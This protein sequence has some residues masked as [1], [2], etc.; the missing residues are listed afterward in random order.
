M[1]RSR[2]KTS[3]GKA[4]R[5]PSKRGMGQAFTRTP[6]GNSPLARYIEENRETGIPVPELIQ[7]FQEYDCDHPE[8]LQQIVAQGSGYR[9]I[10]C[11]RCH[12]VEKKSRPGGRDD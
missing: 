9:F 3:Y 11:E 4:R 2:V 6:Q 7:Q 8:N 1:P 12:R 5:T 10:R